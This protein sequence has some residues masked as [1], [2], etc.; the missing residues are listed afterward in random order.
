MDC[1]LE[2]T[3]FEFQVQSMTKV[4]FLKRTCKLSDRFIWSHSSM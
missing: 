3:Q 1:H 4:S 2:G